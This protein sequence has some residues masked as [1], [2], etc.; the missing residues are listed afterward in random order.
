PALG[1]SLK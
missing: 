1:E